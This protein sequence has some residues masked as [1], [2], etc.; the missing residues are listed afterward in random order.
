MARIDM[1]DGCIISLLIGLSMMGYFLMLS[2]GLTQA[3]ENELGVVVERMAIETEALKVQT[4]KIIL[5][6]K[7]IDRDDWILDGF[8]H[9][10]WDRS[11]EYDVMAGE[12][13]ADGSVRTSLIQRCE[14][15]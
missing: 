13:L 14:E 11:C 12:L 6:E 2:S 1:K 7:M 8:M 3:A 15:E 9:G 5:Y 4:S 10:T